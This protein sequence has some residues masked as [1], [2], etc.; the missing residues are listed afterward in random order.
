MSQLASQREHSTVFREQK[1]CFIWHTTVKRSCNIYSSQTEQFSASN[2]KIQS[3]TKPD[4]ISQFLSRLEKNTHSFCLLTFASLYLCIESTSVGTLCLEFNYLSFT[5]GKYRSF[6]CEMS[7]VLKLKANNN[8]PSS[9][10]M[11]A[12]SLSNKISVR[13]STSVQLLVS[14]R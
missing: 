5:L 3:P 8:K 13:T 14:S 7:Q 1:T 12:F 4:L 6:F 10:S 11:A 2:H 9:H